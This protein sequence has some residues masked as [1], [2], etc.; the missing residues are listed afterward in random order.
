MPEQGYLLRN[1]E[2]AKKIKMTLTDLAI[3]MGVNL[4]IRR[5]HGKFQTG[6]A[7]RVKIQNGNA[8]LDV[9]GV[10]NTIKAAQKDLVKQ[11][12]GKAVVVDA[13]GDCEESYQLSWIVNG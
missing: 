11:L 13:G 8:L 1:C 9:A 7:G 12:S 10:G 5:A 2:M 4:S 3:M 6:F